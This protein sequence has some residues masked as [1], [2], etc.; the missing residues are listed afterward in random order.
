MPLFG[1]KKVI[2]VTKPI[3]AMLSLLWL[4]WPNFKFQ[5]HFHLFSML[6][7]KIL[8][9]NLIFFNYRIKAIVMLPRSKIKSPLAVA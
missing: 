8:E 4:Y 6:L 7:K 9:A 1:S 5:A 3:L 2:V